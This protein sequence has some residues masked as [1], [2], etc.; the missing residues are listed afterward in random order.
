MEPGCTR[1]GARVC[2]GSGLAERRVLPLRV[3]AWVPAV[4][5][6]MHLGSGAGL[7][8]PLRRCSGCGTG[9]HAFD[10]PANDSTDPDHPPD[11]TVPS[12]RVGRAPAV[13]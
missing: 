7:L 1:D 13:D 10:G 11:H 5:A 8:M 4:L 3:R 12:T 2:R 9:T 6:T